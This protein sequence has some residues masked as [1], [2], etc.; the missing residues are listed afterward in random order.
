MPVATFTSAHACIIPNDTERACLRRDAIAIG[1]KINSLRFLAHSPQAT[2]DRVGVSAAIVTGY[3]LST[4][5]RW[6]YHDPADDDLLALQSTIDTGHR[7]VRAVTCLTAP[8][9][10]SALNAGRHMRAGLPQ[11]RA[12]H[13]RPMVPERRG[14][15]S[16]RSRSGR[17]LSPTRRVLHADG[18][19]RPV[20]DS[21]VTSGPQ[22]LVLSTVMSDGSITQSRARSASVPP[23]LSDF[24]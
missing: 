2:H 9:P 20:G 8:T 13:V 12:R 4:L 15:Q 11:R 21:L 5:R 6:R 18:R 7:L 24:R 1:D 23:R 16:T 14:Q 19:L 3:S 22:G 17:S 10:M